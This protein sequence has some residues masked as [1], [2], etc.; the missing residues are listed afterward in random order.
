MR[1]TVEDGG[2]ATMRQT[3]FALLALLLIVAVAAL[4]GCGKQEAAGTGGGGGAKAAQPGG[5][6]TPAG[7]A[8]VGDTVTLGNVKFTLAAV[9]AGPSK[10]APNSRVAV[11]VRG[12]VEN[13]GKD[14]TSVTT[15][16]WLVLADPEERTYRVTKEANYPGEER[17]DGYLDAGKKRDGWVAFDVVPKDGD[18]LLTLQLPG[19]GAEA[20]FKFPLPK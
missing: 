1:Q 15:P 18:W 16:S 11:F 17:M 19:G 10:L 6:G 14:A 2:V 4:A 8:K 5:A 13:A 3:R 9:Q 20:K 12:T 7:P